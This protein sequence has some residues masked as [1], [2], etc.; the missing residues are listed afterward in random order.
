MI[1]QK[2][3]KEYAELNSYLFNFMNISSQ[4]V[5]RAHIEDLKR[6]RLDSICM[7]VMRSQRDFYEAFYSAKQTLANRKLYN[8]TI[9]L[10]VM[11][12]YRNSY[13]IAM[14]DLKSI[15]ERLDD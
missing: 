6:E 10:G 5:Y 3:H 8:D 14:E 9:I 2:L 13:R 15:G 1:S 7:H 4:L 11:H 12:Q